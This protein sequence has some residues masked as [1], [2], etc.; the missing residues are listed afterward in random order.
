MLTDDSR[1]G[2]DVTHEGRTVLLTRAG[3]VY[4]LT[5]PGEDATC[6]DIDL[7]LARAAEKYPEDIDELLDVRLVVEAEEI[8]A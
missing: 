1:P 3:R 7:C 6:A 4:L 2:L 5:E 8:A